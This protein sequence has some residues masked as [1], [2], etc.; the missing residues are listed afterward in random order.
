MRCFLRSEETGSNEGGLTQRD[1]RGKRKTQRNRKTQSTGRRTHLWTTDFG[2][3]CEPVLPLP[4]RLQAPELSRSSNQ[5][6][7]KEG[8]FSWLFSEPFSPA[9]SASASRRSSH[10]PEVD[11]RQ[12]QPPHSYLQPS[13]PP[14]PPVVT[15]SRLCHL[16]LRNPR[17]RHDQCGP[18]VPPALPHLLLSTS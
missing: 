1:Q 18:T 9:F 15:C 13:C 2:A 10:L 11:S 12:R 3:L 4:W 8:P 17:C 5:P 16:H 14:P 7:G 6:G